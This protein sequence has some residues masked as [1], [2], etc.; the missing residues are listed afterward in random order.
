MARALLCV[1]RMEDI[2]VPDIRPST[3]GF[4]W[5]LVPLALFPFL[6]SV[7]SAVW[8]ETDGHRT[9][10]RYRDWPAVFCGLGLVVGGLALWR[11]ERKDRRRQGEM[12]F[13]LILAAVG[14]WHLLRGF[15]IVGPIST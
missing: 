8:T 6:V 13:A 2:T 7:H 15:G 1:P 11:S 9:L 5:M 3:R 4:K 12:V 10:V 14:L